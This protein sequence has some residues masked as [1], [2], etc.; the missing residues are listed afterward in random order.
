MSLTQRIVNQ[1]TKY[2]KK[3][4]SLFQDNLP[5]IIEFLILNNPFSRKVQ[6]GLVLGMVLINLWS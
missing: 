3:F 4:Y 1:I 6:V 2:I 5:Q